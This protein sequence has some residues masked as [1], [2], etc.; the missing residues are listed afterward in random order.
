[1][2]EGRELI[3]REAAVGKLAPQK[4]P[5]ERGRGERIEDPGHLNAVEF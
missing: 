1:M 5:G 3:L 4:D 2:A